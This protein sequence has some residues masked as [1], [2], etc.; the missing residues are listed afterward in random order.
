MANLKKYFG[1]GNNC[2]CWWIGGRHKGQQGFKRD[3]GFWLDN[4]SG[5]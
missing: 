4:M 1:G 5:R 3:S 2:K